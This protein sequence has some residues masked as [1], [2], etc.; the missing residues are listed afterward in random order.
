[1]Q[2]G[3]M[4]ASYNHPAWERVLAGDYSRAP[5]TPDSVMVKRALDLG[6]C[7]EPLG[8]DSLWTT[9]HYGSPYSMQPNPLRWLACWAGRTERIDL[10]SAVVVAPWWN[11]V[12]LAAELWMLDNLLVGRRLLAG[13]GQ[14]FV[15]DEPL[16]ALRWRGSPDRSPRDVAPSG[17]MEEVNDVDERDIPG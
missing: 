9:E 11:P 2:V 1:M 12:R 3:A 14:L 17:H 13:F 10:G 8:Y 6:G 15:A 16:G 7:V 5:E 4:I